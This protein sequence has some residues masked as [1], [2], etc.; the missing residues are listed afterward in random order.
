MAPFL[1]KCKTK[2]A[3]EEESCDED[4]PKEDQKPVTSIISAYQ[5]LSPSVKV[6]T[7]RFYFFLENNQ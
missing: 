1:V 2:T 7:I 3:H 6:Y 4:G 5:L